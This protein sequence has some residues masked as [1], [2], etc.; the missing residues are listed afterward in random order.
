MLGTGDTMSKIDE[1]M[2]EFWKKWKF[3]ELIV[4]HN[5]IAYL[6]LEQKTEETMN[7]TKEKFMIDLRNLIKEAKKEENYGEDDQG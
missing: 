5:I 6:C 2:E 4:V 1:M 3:P 7:E